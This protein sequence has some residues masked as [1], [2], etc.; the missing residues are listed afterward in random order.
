MAAHFINIDRDTP[1][2]LPPDLRDWVERDH[3]VH[4][5]IDAVAQ[6][7][8][9]AA[10]VNKRGTGSLEYPPGLLLGLLVYS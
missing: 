8:V 6:L 7:D 9:S 3:L 10:Q 2:L 1:L 5:I 4:F